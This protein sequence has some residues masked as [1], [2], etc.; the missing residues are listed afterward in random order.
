MEEMRMHKAGFMQLGMQKREEMH[1]E[2]RMPM[3]S[4]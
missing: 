1:R 2:T 3:S 4:R